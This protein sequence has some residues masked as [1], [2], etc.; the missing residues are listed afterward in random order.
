MKKSSNRKS[1]F[2]QKFHS[3]LPNLTAD[4]LN[5]VFNSIDKELHMRRVVRELNDNFLRNWSEAFDL[6]S[7]MAQAC[8]YNYELDERKLRKFLEERMPKGVVKNFLQRLGDLSNDSSEGEMTDAEYESL[9]NRVANLKKKYPRK[10]A[11][12]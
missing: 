5:T 6:I 12:K 2:L 9:D 1:L 10:R 4:E 3:C 7:E 11:K 8:S